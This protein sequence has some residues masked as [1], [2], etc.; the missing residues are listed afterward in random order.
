MLLCLWGTT[1]AD[2]LEY[3]EQKS[4]LDKKQHLTKKYCT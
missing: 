3:K 1:T 4:S 2:Q